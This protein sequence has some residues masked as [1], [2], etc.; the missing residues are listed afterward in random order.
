VIKLTTPFVQSYMVMTVNLES[1]A[2]ASASGAKLKPLP[3]VI[4]MRFALK[5]I[6]MI[7]KKMV[8]PVKKNFRI[9]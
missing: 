5:I 1:R 8:F 7:E 4:E 2:V 6:T 9:Q 3:L